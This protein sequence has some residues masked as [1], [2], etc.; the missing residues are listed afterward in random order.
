MSGSATPRRSQ[1]TKSRLWAAWFTPISA[2]LVLWGAFFAF[3]GLGALPLVSAN[4]LLPW[5]S[6]L[7]GAVLVGWGTTLAFAGRIAFRRGD[8]E[9]M[10][11]LL[12]GLFMWLL[13]EGAFSLYLG[14]FINAGVD[15]AVMVLFAIPLAKGIASHPRP[16]NPS[17]RDHEPLEHDPQ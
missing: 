6:A 10:G 2:I 7:Y 9:L 11:I 13:I 3:F 16:E 15:V 14:V 5:E 1:T 8:R 17:P 4:V 12:I